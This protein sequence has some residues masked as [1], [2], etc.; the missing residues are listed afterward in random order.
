[1]RSDMDVTCRQCIFLLA[2]FAVSTCVAAASPI[3]VEEWDI[4]FSGL[5]TS[6]QMPMRVVFSIRNHTRRDLYIYCSVQKRLQN[7][8]QDIAPSIDALKPVKS[9]KL[10]RIATDSTTM[11]RWD[12]LEQKFFIKDPIGT[13]RLQL[14]VYSEPWKKV[15]RIISSKGFVIH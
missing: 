9:I 15:E 8:W 13:Y 2:L 4:G 10:K 12:Y 6:V 1:M 3:P 5:P 11:L 14:H 7:G